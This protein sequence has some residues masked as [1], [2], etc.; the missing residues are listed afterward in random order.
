MFFIT[1]QLNSNFGKKN[2]IDWALQKID[3]PSLQK[4]FMLSVQF[5]N[6]FKQTYTYIS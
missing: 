1:M 2:G 5:L 3:K 4:Y 6:T